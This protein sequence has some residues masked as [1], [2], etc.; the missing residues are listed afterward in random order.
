MCSARAVYGSP[1]YIVK[2]GQTRCAHEAPTVS[3][4]APA[5]SFAVS[6]FEHVNPRDQ[7]STVIT[8]QNNSPTMVDTHE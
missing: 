4:D 8:L 1:V 5:L 6:S 3:R 2:G 7:V